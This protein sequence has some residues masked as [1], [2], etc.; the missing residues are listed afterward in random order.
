MPQSTA[1]AAIRA[2]SRIRK[3][4]SGP[5]IQLRQVTDKGRYMVGLYRPT[6]GGY[7][8]SL[9]RR[10]EGGKQEALGTYPL[11]QPPR[12]GDTLAL[13]L[14]AQEDRLTVL[15]DGIVR[16]EANDKAIREAGNWGIQANEAWFESVEVQPLPAAVAG[17]KLW[18]T[19]EK[20]P[21]Q[22][23]VSWENGAVRL[24]KTVIATDS[25]AVRDLVFRASMKFGTD[26]GGGAHLLVRHQEKKHSY[27]LALNGKVIEL[28]LTQGGNVRVLKSWPVP[29]KYQPEDWL[30]L[31]V[32]AIGPQLTVSVADQ[33]LGT[34][35]DSTLMATGGVSVGVVR[36]GYFKDIEYVPLDAAAV[37]PSPNL[38]VSSSSVATATKDA[39]FI[40]T[41]GMKFVPVPGTQVLFSI[42][43]TRVQ[44]YM[45]YA[46]AEESAG[47]KVDD[48]WKKQ[49]KDGV[50][51]G[52]EFDHPVAGVSWE[53]AQAFCQW[54]TERE[55]ANGKL[56]KGQRYRLPTDEEWST[57]VGLP[58]EKGVT[59]FAKS[60]RN[61]VDFPWGKDWPPMKNAGN[62][63]DETY[64]NKFPIP[65]ASNPANITGAWIEGYND[66]Y[67]TT[68]PVGSFPAN[69]H[70]LYD[71]GGNLWQWCEDWWTQE[72]KER[73]LRGASWGNSD[74][75]ALRSSDRFHLPPSTHHYYRGFRCVLEPAPSTAA[76]SPSP[77]LPV[78]A[79]NASPARSASHSDAGGRSDAGGSKSSDPKFPP[80]L[81]VKLF[82]KPEDLPADLRKPG[83]GVTWE[84]GWISSS[85]A[86]G[87]LINSGQTWSDAGIRFRARVQDQKLAPASIRDVVD[88]GRSAVNYQVSA[89]FSDR[90][91]R[92]SHF[93]SK[94]G[95]TLA[96]DT[97]G[98]WPARPEDLAEG[99][100]H[101]IEL[102][103]VKD[104]L[105]VRIDDRLLGVVSDARLRSGR[106][107][108]FL[109]SPVRDVE[110]INLDGLPEAEAL[111][112][113][114]VDEKGNDLRGKAGTAK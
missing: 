21:K 91:W 53:D 78:P 108:P 70:G 109:M 75:G 5:M 107:K 12:E 114:G 24:D 76:V 47:K 110:V 35:E 112:L 13:E 31:E 9:L 98:V 84:D 72:H 74:R 46:K 40:N 8:V 87:L 67:A 3:G 7:H 22:Q 100:E 50:P 61:D 25:P 63:A 45:A 59:P 69:V 37:S 66:K 94:G 99:K 101:M 16:I 83:S 96:D 54:L 79:R 38:P 28:R 85:K 89:T 10:I 20:L 44:D 81:W 82:T 29:E 97:L 57:A 34:V 1:D 33:V 77:S 15:V 56:T 42:W 60:G 23:G 6:D 49:S 58:P 17:I 105:V 95:E 103:A 106:M 113:L 111:R 55:T 14:R 48:A 41:L 39:P 19:P 11:P 4:T 32:K 18:E 65:D 26:N 30:R 104:R 52:H 64:H 36:T 62:F 93:S 27:A 80:G 51:I 43:L 86:V 102:A 71:M 88:P 73:V 92:L 2:R 68:S 90:K